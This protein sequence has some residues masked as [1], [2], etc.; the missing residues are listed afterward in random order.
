MCRRPLGLAS[1]GDTENL[2]QLFSALEA[3]AKATAPVNQTAA[4]VASLDDG[5]PAVDV[6]REGNG[7]PLSETDPALLEATE[8][9]IPSNDAALEDR[10]RKPEAIRC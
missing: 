8:A 7:H 3:A 9:A 5:T 1:Q 4:V 10:L 2:D 6:E